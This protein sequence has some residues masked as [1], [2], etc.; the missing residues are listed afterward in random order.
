MGFIKYSETSRQ[1]SNKLRLEI[2]IGKPYTHYSFHLWKRN[3]PYHNFNISLFNNSGQELGDNHLVAPPCF[4]RTNILFKVVLI[5]LHYA[6]CFG[7]INITV[8]HNHR[9]DTH[10]FGTLPLIDSVF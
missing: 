10:Q 1:G 5:K 9:I 6:R 2:R 4:F 3:I 8:G 7:D